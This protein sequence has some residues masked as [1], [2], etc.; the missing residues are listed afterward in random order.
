MSR[1]LRHASLLGVLVALVAGLTVSVE[2][3]GAAVAPPSTSLVGTFSIDPGRCQA[4]G[5]PTGSYLQIE[6]DGVAVPNLG[7]TCGADGWGYTPLTQ[8]TTGL[9]TGA[10]QL[11]PAPTFSTSGNSLA[12]GIIRPVRFL[13]DSLGLATTCA[14]QTAA[15]TASGACAP[16][17][18]GFAPPSLDQVAP[19]TGTCPVA[20]VGA[21]V[22]GDLSSLGLTW[23]GFA[24]TPSLP[25]AL[26]DPLAALGA[27]AS[28]TCVTASGCDAIGIANDPGAPSATCVTASS[29]GSCD[30]F[31]TIDPASGAYTLALS[32]GVA[33]SVLPD[34][35]LHLVLRGTFHAGPPPSPAAGNRSGVT[36][37]VAAGTPPTST[38]TT[39]TG[40]G[41][42]PSAVSAPASGNDPGGVQQLVGTLTLSPATCPGSSPQGSFLTIAFAST[43]EANPASSC[44]GGV[45]TLLQPG[46]SGLGLG[47]FT[48]DPSP[49]FDANGN[50]QSGAVVTPTL[51]KGYRFGLG[52]SP[53]DVQDAPSGPVTFDPPLAVVQGT[54]LAVDLRSLDV[55]YDGPANTTCVQSAG[56][57]C[58]QEGSRVATGTYDPSTGDVVLDWF[59][60]QDFTGGSGEVDFHLSGHFSGSESVADPSVLAQ[61]ATTTYVVTSSSVDAE[62]FPASTPS[63]SSGS[64]SSTST[65]TT[66]DPSVSTAPPRVV[67]IEESASSGLGHHSSSSPW[68]VLIVVIGVV[69]TAGLLLAGRR[70][71]RAGRVPREEST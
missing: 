39:T 8:G 19:G 49:T 64:P 68:P 65:S 41:A 36:P 33:L 29:P 6:V 53:D 28:P 24:P 25:A 21:C 5:A 71:R 34:A 62:S 61:L 56:L 18:S 60:S 55:T 27:L 3:I 4:S 54:N 20:T 10:Y 59:S 63:G 11:D 52:T 32:T 31:G 47:A 67:R 13:A 15:P 12:A 50:S 1:G 16:G 70:S 45:D 22:R 48:P 9:V 46:T 14:N 35:V 30:L 42:G 58:W 51:F 7:S 66:T 44:D 38:T 57:G 40:S 69:A 2:P 26:K 17:T 23:A 43:S 37:V